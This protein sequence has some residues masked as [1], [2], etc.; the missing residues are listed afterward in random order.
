MRCPSSTY[1]LGELRADWDVGRAVSIDQQVEQAGSQT[2]VAVGRVPHR[3][4]SRSRRPTPKIWRLLL[5]TAILAAWN[6]GIV[7]FTPI[8]VYPLWLVVDAAHVHA[9]H[10]TWSHAMW[11]AFPPVVA[12][13]RAR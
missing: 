6:A 10:L 3:T 2:G 12:M 5:A 8:A 13:S 1:T 4:P 7:W 11:P 9:Y